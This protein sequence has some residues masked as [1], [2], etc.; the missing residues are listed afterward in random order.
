MYWFLSFVLIGGL[1]AILVDQVPMQADISM[2]VRFFGKGKLLLKKLKTTKFYQ[3]SMLLSKIQTTYIT[4]YI[5]RKY[6]TL[7]KYL[8]LSNHILIFDRYDT[9]I[10]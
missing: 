10:F 2:V 4:Y 1:L 9:M 5:I 8:R 7:V 6:V 3:R